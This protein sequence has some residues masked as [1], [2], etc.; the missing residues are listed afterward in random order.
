MAAS[1]RWVIWR[2]GTG[3]QLKIGR[4]PDLLVISDGPSQVSLLGSLR[5]ISVFVVSDEKKILKKDDL[6]QPYRL[7]G[8]PPLPALIY[9]L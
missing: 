4:S 9:A 2:D 7:G 5:Y 1:A 6:A 8:K 3:C